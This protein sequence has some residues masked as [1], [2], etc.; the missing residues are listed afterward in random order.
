MR[1]KKRRAILATFVGWL[2]LVCVYASA[3]VVSQ[4]TSPNAIGY[5]KLW[6]W[7]LGFFSLTRLPILVLVLL[8]VIFLEGRIIEKGGERDS[9]RH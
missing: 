2:L 5:E 9:R 4:T 3:Y 6:T 8:V 7:Q 1:S